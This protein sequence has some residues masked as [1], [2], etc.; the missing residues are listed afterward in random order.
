MPQNCTALVHMGSQILTAILHPM[1]SLWNQ[2]NGEMMALEKITK[3]NTPE[4]I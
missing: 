4:R 3:T 1:D 2:T